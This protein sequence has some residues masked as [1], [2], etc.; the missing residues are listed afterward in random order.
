MV[1]IITLNSIL[2]TTFNDKILRRAPN[3]ELINKKIFDAYISRDEKLAL[4]VG[5]GNRIE[6]HLL[7]DTDH[8][9]EIIED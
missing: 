4:A 2:E 7:F 9:I 5:Q 1:K 8:E 6:K 3:G